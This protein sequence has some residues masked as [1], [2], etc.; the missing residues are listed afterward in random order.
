MVKDDAGLMRILN[1]L[2]VSTAIHVFF[3][4]IT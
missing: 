4:G 1:F 2:N 3:D